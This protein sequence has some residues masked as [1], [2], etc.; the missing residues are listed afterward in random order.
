[1]VE[2]REV[3][4]T[5]KAV[6]IARNITIAVKLRKKYKLKSTEKF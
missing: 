4:V 1:M 5:F 3:K 2:L 6:W